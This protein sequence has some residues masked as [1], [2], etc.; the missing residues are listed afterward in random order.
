[1]N[2]RMID[3]KRTDTPDDHTH[4]LEA[5]APWPV[6]ECLISSWWKDTTK[7]TNI[8][9]AKEP[10]FGGVVSSAF[11]VDLGCL[12]LKQG[13]VSQFRT[14]LE[15][16]TEF[17]ALM[18]SQN[19][20]VMAEYPLVVKILQESM[21]YARQLGFDAPQGVRK[22]LSVLGSLD[23]V[24]QCSERI[25]LGGKDGQPFY[26]AGPDDDVEAVINKLTLKCGR[27]NFNYTIIEN[28]QYPDFFN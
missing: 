3:N 4:G 24:A 19:P 22:A 25:P 17:R 16:E 12:G 1:M 14:K 15:Y 26:M 28:P 2:R 21:R 27:G 23:A 9:I 10:P 20:M 7:L 5:A 6:F 18:V 11:L 13:F 8:L